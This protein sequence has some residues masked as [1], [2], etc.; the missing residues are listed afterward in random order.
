M[1][2]IFGKQNKRLGF[3]KFIFSF[4]PHT[5]KT[6]LFLTQRNKR[7]VG[8]VCLVSRLLLVFLGVKDDSVVF[9]LEPLHGVVLD[10][11]VGGADTA[12]LLPGNENK[13]EEIV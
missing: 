10:K 12:G 8:C 1:I 7:V 4:R 2:K 5:D 11:L 6:I 13:K 9:L 3:S